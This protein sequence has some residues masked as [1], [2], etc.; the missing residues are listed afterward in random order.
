MEISVAGQTYTFL[1]SLIFGAIL[2]LFYDI[3]RIFR[4]AFDFGKIAV[5]I[6]DALFFTISAVLTFIFIFTVNSGEIRFFILIGILAGAVIYYYTI[7][8][9]IYKSAKVIIGFVKMIIRGIL[10]IILKPF[11]LIYRLMK[12]IFKKIKNLF[13]IFSKKINFLFK[14]KLKKFKIEAGM[15][16]NK[17]I[18]LAQKAQPK[19][20]KEI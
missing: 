8:M 17:K 14:F 13:K 16:K 11:Y 3:F 10:R 15:K 12:P 2:G 20:T 5:F 19:S 4:I 18:R 9:L 7:G 1:M 6:E